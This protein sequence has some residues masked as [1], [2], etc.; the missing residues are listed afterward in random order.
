M[1]YDKRMNQLFGCGMF[2]PIDPVHL[3]VRKGL[4]KRF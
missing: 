1:D 4:I 3:G 2:E